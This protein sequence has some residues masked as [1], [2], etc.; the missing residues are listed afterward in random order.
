MI[1]MIRTAWYGN[2]KAILL[3]V[4]GFPVLILLN[5]L[6]FLILKLLKRSESK[7][8]KIST[9]ALIVLFI[10]TLMIASRH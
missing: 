2:D 10:P 4:V 9:I 1:H 6:I 7:I 3:T 5:A 8:Y